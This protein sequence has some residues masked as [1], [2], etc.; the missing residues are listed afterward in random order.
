MKESSG[1]SKNI[2]KNQED[3]K[4]PWNDG[5]NKMKSKEWSDRKDERAERK[6]SKVSEAANLIKIK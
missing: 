2:E 3:A 5:L 6:F 1:K 4:I